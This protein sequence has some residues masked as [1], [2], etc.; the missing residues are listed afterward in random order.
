M[1]RFFAIV[2]AG[3][4]L[5]PIAP[6]AT[7]GPVF[8]LRAV[9]NP[10]LGYFI[11]SLTPGGTKRG[12]VIVS[13]TGT[14]SGTVKLFS[15][16][17]TTGKTSGTV[18]LTDQKPVRAGAWITLDQT[19]LTLAPGAHRQVGFT[20]KPP[21]G[22]EPGQWVGGIVA[23]T[24]HQVTG[25][26][27]KQKANVQIRIRDL[28]IV[29]VQV[30]VP[31][32]QSIAFKV[33]AVKTGGQRG[34]QQVITYMEN[35]GS[36]LVKPLGTVT[37]LDSGGRRLQVLKFTMD[38]FL[39]HTAI[40]YPVLLKKALPPG[41]YQAIVHVTVPG[42]AG[43]EGTKVNVTRPLAVSKEDVQQVFTSASPT[44]APPETTAAPA[45]SSS[46]SH[47][48]PLIGLIAGAVLLLLA[49]VLWRILRRRP[50]APVAPAATVEP[51]VV[52][53]RTAPPP[54]APVAEE[55]A[56]VPEPA[57]W[58][59]PGEPAPPLPPPPPP[60]PSPAAPA[61]EHLWEVAYER[62]ELGADGVW[63]FPHRCRTCGA[64]LL[65]RDVAD[66]S[67]QSRS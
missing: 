34:F 26:K 48:W 46:S 22:V 36:V 64:E 41:S 18:Y 56:P 44:Q 15:A 55:P 4:V 10:K 3:L 53:A 65:A 39:P 54:P 23:E 60:E 1:R 37:I 11:Y 49:A 45:A 13:N 31:G 17:A 47:S 28:T 24:T 19:Q 57:P 63:R 59:E 8:G 58:P 67:A 33:G 16:D 20:V 27:S 21:Q 66:A 51:A 38:T 5:A 29:A 9:G 50:S 30:N 62:G 6:A 7:S 52:E 43:V 14:A 2:L 61:H 35:D 25:P 40:E 42:A 12:A 32:K